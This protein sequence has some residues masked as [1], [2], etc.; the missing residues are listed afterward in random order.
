M[1]CQLAGTINIIQ[2]VW[3]AKAEH[4]GCFVGSYQHVEISISHMLMPYRAQGECKT[5]SSICLYFA[6]SELLNILIPG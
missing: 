6:E 3:Q 1:Q 5:K 2:C 4:M